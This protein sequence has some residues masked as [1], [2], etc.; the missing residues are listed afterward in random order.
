[1]CHIAGGLRESCATLSRRAEGHCNFCSG[2]LRRVRDLVGRMARAVS[3]SGGRLDRVRSPVAE[4][5]P[6][7]DSIGAFLRF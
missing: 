4:R 7:G 2:P 1:M 5:F 6:N 3:E